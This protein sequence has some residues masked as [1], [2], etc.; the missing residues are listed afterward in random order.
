MNPKLVAFAV[1]V[2]EILAAGYAAWIVGL[3]SAWF[4]DDDQA[5]RMQDRDW[6]VEG[7]RRLAIALLVATA[8]A[9]VARFVHRRWVVT[10]SSSAWLRSVPVLLGGGIA[11]AGAVG[12]AWFV[13]S[14]PW[15]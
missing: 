3:M 10:S 12:A 13:V 6:V 4:V 8:F 1:L 5:F 15:L 11:L 14:R 7:C 2:A 9:L